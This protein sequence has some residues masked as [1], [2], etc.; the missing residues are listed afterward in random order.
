MRANQPFEIDAVADGPAARLNVS[1]GGLSR[2]YAIASGEHRDYIEFFRALAG[3]FGMRT[4]HV[5]EGP[6]PSWPKA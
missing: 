2:D 3:D 6:A 5:H 1:Y 4:P